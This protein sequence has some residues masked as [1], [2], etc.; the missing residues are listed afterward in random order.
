MET[1]GLLG[2]VPLLRPFRLVNS[3]LLFVVVTLAQFPV[4]QCPSGI[5]LDDDGYPMGDFEDQCLVRVDEDPTS[6]GGLI[7]IWVAAHN[8]GL[9]SEAASADRVHELGFIAQS[10]DGIGDFECCLQFEH[11]GYKGEVQVPE[12]TQ[13]LDGR[14]PEDL[15]NYLRIQSEEAATIPSPTTFYVVER[16]RVN[17]EEIDGL[18]CGANAN[19][20]LERPMATVAADTDATT[21]LHELGHLQGLQHFRDPL[22]QDNFMYSGLLEIE[23][24]NLRRELFCYQCDC[25]ATDN[26]NPNVSVEPLPANQSPCNGQLRDGGVDGSGDE[27]TTGCTAAFGRAPVD[28]WWIVLFGILVFF[29]QLRRSPSFGGQRSQETRLRAVLRDARERRHIRSDRNG[30][31]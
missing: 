27:N 26:R 10:Y 24:D 16:I 17:G 22:G 6:S 3:M 7:G 30:P 25:L 12:A 1:G 8:P 21:W 4:N 14:S 20:P 13:R 2:G 19:P 31:V 23:A 18:T 15:C 29:A 11:R 28:S 5:G 9:L